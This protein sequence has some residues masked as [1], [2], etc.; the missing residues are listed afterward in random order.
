MKTVVFS[1][2]SYDRE[3]LSVA[4]APLGHELTFLEPRLT[5]E[6]VQLA[7]GHQA[8]CVFVNDQLDAAV[9][10]SLAQRGVRVVALRCAGFN[11]VDLPTARELGIKVVRVPAYSPHAVA[12]HTVGLILTLNRKIHRAYARVRDGNF[13]LGGLLGFDLCGRTV[14]V[15][16][17]GQIGAVFAKI[18]SGFGCRLLGYD[19][20]PNANCRELGMEYCDLSKLFAESD[21][22]SLHCPLT[23]E[24]HHLI[25]AQS[26]ANMRNGV[27]IINTSR[28]AVIDTQAVVDGLK[29]G[30][31]G[32]LGLDVYEEEADF[33][34]EDLSNEVIPDDTL[35]R[36]LTFPNVIITGHQAFFTQ[37]AL[38]CIAE[39]TLQ[40]ITDIE[41]VGSSKNEVAGEHS[42]R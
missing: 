11:N 37:E 19:E 28:G 3:F 8:V 41:R 18:M 30:K 17:T 36:L 6:T 5:S 42:Q 21:I 9:L 10:R 15:I 35:S 2:K 38:Q 34:F 23:P 13:Y 27:M 16:G 24:T 26:I 4:A 39:T 40:N 7:N 22:I 32:H 14:G 25:D 29:S 12:E 20:Y 31:I 1:T 33:F